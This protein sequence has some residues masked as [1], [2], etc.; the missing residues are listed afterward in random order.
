L[1]AGVI[2]AWPGFN[3]YRET[4]L[5]CSLVHHEGCLQIMS[6]QYIEWIR[7]LVNR[8]FVEQIKTLTS[9]TTYTE[10]GW[11]LELDEETLIATL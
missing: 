4:L 11:F 1:L 8:R 7:G 10:A 5:D 6:C 3:V 2:K 9:I